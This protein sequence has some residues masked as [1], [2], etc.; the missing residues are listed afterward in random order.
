VGQLHGS[1]PAPRCHR[2]TYA[3]SRPGVGLAQSRYTLGLSTSLRRRSKT[4]TRNTTIRART[5]PCNTRSEPCADRRAM[6]KR[7][8]VF[9]AYE[10]LEPRWGRRGR[11]LLFKCG[12]NSRF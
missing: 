1:V 5:P 2:P 6:D 12:Q 10:I 4:S 7:A 11:R 9:A 3:P 8:P